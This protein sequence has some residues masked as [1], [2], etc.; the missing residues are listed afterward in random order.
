MKAF[1]RLFGLVFLFIFL[2]A[3]GC[4]RSGN[5]EDIQRTGLKIYSMNTSIGSVDKNE[6]NHDI[7]RF[8][9]S[10]GLTNNDKDK[11]FI[12]EATLVLP[13]EFEERLIS[14]QLTVPVNKDILP[15][16]TIEIKGS[17]DFNAKGLSKEDI[18]K[19]NPR[20]LSVRVTDERTISIEK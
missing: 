14:E 11:V 1:N 6:N 7:Q 18:I 3:F 16:D 4:T 9:Y 10:I 17:V 2:L 5:T 13:K 12:K 15:K 20:I 8:S 19:L